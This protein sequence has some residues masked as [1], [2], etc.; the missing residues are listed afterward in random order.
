MFQMIKNAQ[1][2]WLVDQVKKEDATEAD[3]ERAFD[4][5]LE[6]WRER[7][8]GYLSLL[9]DEAHDAYLMD[10]GF[11]KI[12]SIVEYTRKL[13]ELPEKAL[14]ITSVALSAS[15]MDDTAFAELYEQCRSGTANKNQLFTIEQ[16]MASFE[17]ELGKQWRN[18]CFIF[19]KENDVIGLGIPHIEAGTD[20]EGRLFYFGVVPQWRGKGYGAICHRLSLERLKEFRAKTYVGST[21][22]NNVHM[23]RIFERNGCTLRDRKGIYRIDN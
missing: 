20:D 16:T 11:R 17:L 5:L 21:D 12:S 18:H 8:V 10:K 22:V 23:I 15:D 2:Y 13:N 9:M 1:E 19:Y 3:Y 4:Q 7:K 6:E 14:G